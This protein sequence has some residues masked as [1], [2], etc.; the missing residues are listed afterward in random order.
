MK[1]DFH[2]SVSLIAIFII[3]NMIIAF[4]KG[5]GRKNSLVGFLI[6]F[7]L[8]LGLCAFYIRLQSL[9]GFSVSYFSLKGNEVKKGVLLFLILALCLTSYISCCKEYVTLIDSWQ[10][11]ETP[12]FVVAIIFVG[13]V[14]LIALSKNKVIK[15]F[16]LVSFWVI[17][18]CAVFMFALSFRQARFSLIKENLPVNIKQ[19]AIQAT[20]YF[21]HSFGQIFTVIL[22][23]GHKKRADA[24]RTQLLGVGAAGAFLFICL[25]Q[26]LLLLGP[27][28]TELLKFPYA[29]ATASVA[30]GRSYNRMDSFTYYIYFI[31]S[32]I[33]SAVILS[34]ALNVIKDVSKK[35]KKVVATAF[36]VLAIFFV[37]IKPLHAV[38]ESKPFNLILLACEILTPIMFFM[39]LKSDANKNRQ[40]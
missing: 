29:A 14:L 10:L 16:S 30:A 18:V 4:P 35:F 24:K 32:L 2:H 6:C 34:V 38:V 15:M 25:I 13:L 11:K 37:S 5:E 19:S 9:K 26:V 28:V 22:F 17:V 1:K 33:K 21:I 39:L 8:F 31:C 27:D 3:G 36:C 23:I 40:S 12:R 20:T 7:L